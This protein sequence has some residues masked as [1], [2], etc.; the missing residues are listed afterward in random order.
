M[1]LS[2][3]LKNINIIRGG[4]YLLKDISIPFFPGS[5]TIII[6]PSGC[7]KS[8]LL[9]VAAGL[10][11]SDS[12]ELLWNDQPYNSISEKNIKQLRCEAGFVFQDSALW[13]NKSVLQNLSLPL[14]F[15]F[16]QMP[17]KE[18]HKKALYLARKMGYSDQMDLRPSQISSG[19]QKIISFVRAL[20]TD[21]KTLFLD[22]PTLGLDQDSFTSVLSTLLNLKREG[23]T[24]IIATT[25]AKAVSQLCDFLVVMEKGRILETG[26]FQEVIHTSKR[27]VK[28]ALAKVLSEAATYDGSILDLLDHRDE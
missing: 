3:E 14:E 17:S 22:S 9:K 1:G 25:E 7:G 4:T 24:L 26:V 15:H 21:P 28:A 18:I 27:E 6:G 2:V 10:L 13:A 20:M 8:T 5:T 12:G 11:P 16:P 19:E 23:K